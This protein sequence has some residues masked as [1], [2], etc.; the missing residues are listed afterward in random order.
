MI[1]VLCYGDSNTH[2]TAP[3]A[4][5]EDRRRHAPDLRWP[6]VAGAALGP[7]YHLIEEG[8]PGR[9]TV[10]DDPIDGV[11]LN[12]RRYLQACLESHRPL[13][14]VV[15]ML[16]VNDLKRRFSLSAYDIASGVGQL[17]FLT[18][19]VT[20]ASG[21]PAKVI[22]VSP[23]TILCA[24][25]LAPMF[26]GGEETSRQLASA[27]KTQ[28]DRQ[29]AIFLDLAPV[30]RVSPIDGIHFD[31]AGQRAIGSVIAAAIQQA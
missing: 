9:T 7:A 26:A 22:A 31:E 30:A 23:P 24:G 1:N 3:M 11:H 25:W 4:H 12:G 10:F 15:L 18:K 2:G 27:I 16:G 8:L 14:I 21:M 29:G 20:A 19:T 17:V 28:A 6:G 5:A 13:D